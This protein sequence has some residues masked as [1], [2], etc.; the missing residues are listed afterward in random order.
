MIVIDERIEQDLRSRGEFSQLT[1]KQRDG[2]SKVASSGIAEEHDM[3]WV[4]IVQ[5]FTGEELAR[6]FVAIHECSRELMLGRAAVIDRHH[7]SI[8][9]ER[10]LHACIGVEIDIAIGESSAMEEEDRALEV[11][12]H[13]QSVAQGKVDI[14]W[15]EHTDGDILRLRRL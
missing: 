13:M 12:V 11:F 14:E 5:E 6:N 1:R 2:S 3:L 7:A 4:D 10:H 8:E 9:L 15:R